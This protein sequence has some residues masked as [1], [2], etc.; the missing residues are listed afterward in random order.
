MCQHVVICWFVVRPA[1]PVCN[2]VLPL[3]V[4]ACCGWRGLSWW[5]AFYMFLLCF[6][7][8]APLCLFARY[9]CR[10]FCLHGGFYHVF[11]GMWS[12]LFIKNVKKY[13]QTIWMGVLSSCRW[14]CNVL[15]I[16]RSRMNNEKWWSFLKK[17]LLRWGFV[18][19]RWGDWALFTISLTILTFSNRLSPRAKE[20]RVNP[21]CVF[22]EI[23]TV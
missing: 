18:G 11:G 8:F 7:P 12:I 17:I 2:F 1:L 23:S 15:V 21:R 3:R 9:S 20:G 5:W 4:S 13:R 10:F 19:L 22:A 14:Y 16:H 6:L